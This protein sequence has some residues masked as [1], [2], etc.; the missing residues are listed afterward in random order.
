MQWKC[1]N[2]GFD[3]SCVPLYCDT[4]YRT[5]DNPNI[6]CYLH[7]DI[8]KGHLYLPPLFDGSNSLG[9]L[10]KPLEFCF[11]N[12]KLLSKLGTGLSLLY[13]FQNFQ[14]SFVFYLSFDQQ[15]I[16]LGQVALEETFVQANGLSR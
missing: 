2:I 6:F 10:W 5:V 15:K 3:G 14:F 12:V 11:I 1:L 8:F 7:P 13:I 16:D 4:L 9:H